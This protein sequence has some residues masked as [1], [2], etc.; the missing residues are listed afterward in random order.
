MLA[1]IEDELQRQIA[2]L[3]SPRMP[4]L[5]EMLV[6]HMGWSAESAASE[7]A[8][9]RVRPLIVLLVAASVDGRWMDAAPAAA[10][11]ELIHNFSLVHDDIQ[12]NSPTRRGR[13]ALWKK[14]GTPM[15][16]NAGD[17]LY[18]IANQA[19]LDLSKVFGAELVLRVSA[20]L[21]RAC[22]E[23][24]S[25]QF[26]DLAYQGRVDLSIEDY[27]PMV[28]AKTAALLA[29]SS[30]V[31]AILGGAGETTV[32]QYRAFGRLLGLAFQVQDDILGIWG[33]EALTGKSTASDLVEGKSTLPVLYALSRDSEFSK[34][35]ASPPIQPQEVQEL[36]QMLTNAGAQEFS[37]R[38]GRRLTEEARS[39]LQRSQPQGEA[40]EALVELTEKLLERAA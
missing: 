25:G 29:A 6:Y 35:W 32:E 34:R 27:W 5:H 23:L 18:T 14:Y 2:R 40:G 37:L 17:S 28:E 21:Q 11:V 10:A 9:K 13:A 19:V 12:D 20:I 26:L 30:H 7:A 15:A 8:G 16:I 31:G 1:A 36:A 22:L 24:T 33:N 39:A 38:E 4:D 3:D